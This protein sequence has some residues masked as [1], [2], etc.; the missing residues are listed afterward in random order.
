MFGIFYCL[1]FVFLEIIFGFG[2][3]IVYKYMIYW[4]G[5][6]LVYSRIEFLGL[7]D[8]RFRFRFFLGSWVIDYGILIL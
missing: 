2:V 3:W 4:K 8:Y 5:R 7:F 6:E 1:Y